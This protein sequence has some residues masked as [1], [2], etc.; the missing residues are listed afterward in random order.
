VIDQTTGLNIRKSTTDLLH[1]LWI[2]QDVERFD[3]TFKIPRVD[4]HDRGLSMLLNHN[5]LLGIAHRLLGQLRGSIVKISCCD[6][7]HVSSLDGKY[8]MLNFLPV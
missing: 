8:K 6:S 4:Q 1:R 7:F 2:G 3:Q 5:W